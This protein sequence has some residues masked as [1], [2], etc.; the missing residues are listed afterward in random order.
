MSSTSN[1]KATG[2]MVVGPAGLGLIKELIQ[3]ETLAQFW[4]C[5]LLFALGLVSFAQLKSSDNQ[6][7]WRRTANHSYYL[8]HNTNIVGR[9]LGEFPTLRACFFR[10]VL[11][12][13]SSC[14]QSARWSVT[15]QETSHGQVM[16][17][18]FLR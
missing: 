6:F 2:G 7:G 5:L 9:R 3:V 11:I 15:E 12:V 10:T 14:P 4:R 8:S 1:T 16:L 18:I 13:H 17:G